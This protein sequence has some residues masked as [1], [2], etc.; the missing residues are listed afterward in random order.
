MS[1]ESRSKIEIRPWGACSMKAIGELFAYREL[2]LAFLVRDIKVRYKQTAVGIIWIVLQ[3]LCFVSIFSFVISKVGSVPTGDVP[4]PVY[5]LGAFVPWM[6]FSKGLADGS[7]SLIN[8]GSLVTKVYFPRAL[9]PISSVCGGIIDASVTILALLSLMLLSGILPPLSFV[10]VPLALAG[11]VIASLG[12]TMWL[13]ALNALFRDIR[14]VIPFLTQ[15]W[16]LVT[17]I[18][19][20]LAVVP[21]KWRIVYALNPIVFPVEL[22]RSVAFGIP[23][24][25]VGLLSISAFVSLFM[26]ISGFYFFKSIEAKVVDFV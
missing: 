20:P 21:D 11:A 14:Y 22:F 12:V 2:F 3:P 18:F 24:Q 13:S 8:S 10:L 15:I 17:P 26:L 1:D 6:I 5:A 19:Y 7:N 23:F 25:D 16:M 9:L 4:Y